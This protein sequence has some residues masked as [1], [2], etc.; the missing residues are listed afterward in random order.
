MAIV[1][2]KIGEARARGETYEGTADVANW[3]STELRK[4][5]MVDADWQNVRTRVEFVVGVMRFERDKAQRDERIEKEIARKRELVDK[6]RGETR[7]RHEADLKMLEDRLRMKPRPI[8]EESRRLATKY[9]EQLDR[10][11]KETK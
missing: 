3:L 4:R 5:K 11:V 10:T 2:R 6:S 1:A 8:H 9:W 7:A